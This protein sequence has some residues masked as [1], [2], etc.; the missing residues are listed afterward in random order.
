MHGEMELASKASQPEIS[1]FGSHRDELSTSN[2]VEE[3]TV[4]ASDATR[5]I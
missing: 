4:D 1:S 3:Q 2:N 5:D